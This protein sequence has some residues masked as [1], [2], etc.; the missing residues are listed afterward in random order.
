MAVLRL[1]GDNRP[2][3]T[4]RQNVQRLIAVA[5]VTWGVVSGSA[6]WL[7]YQAGER[8]SA[9][10]L[11]TG[12]LMLV[13]LVAM[14]YACRAELQPSGLAR[15]AHVVQ[16]ASAFGIALLVP[17]TFLPIY[18]IIWIATAVRLYSVNT[19]LWLMAGIT[20]SWYLVMRFL[21]DENGAFL[22]TAMFA[23][24]HLFAILSARSVA[25]AENA[26]DQMATLNREL[27]ATQHLLSEAARQ[28]ER[29]RIARDLHD[30]LGHQLTALAINLQIAER[31]A[32]GDAKPRIAESRAL[33]RLLLSDVREAVS[34]LRE[35]AVL[36]FRR[37]IALVTDKAPGIE[38]QLDIE[39]TL[40]INDVEIAESLLRCV[41]EALTN[42]LRHAGA[43]R[44][45]IRLWQA[46]GRIR[47]HVRDDGEAPRDVHE[48]N[49]L[50][51]MRERLARLKGSL[52]LDTAG[53]A[54]S[55]H[56]EI[57]LPA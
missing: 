36:D 15:A 34:T 10:W 23:T 32:S 13:N 39:E 11:P 1:P 4:R 57:P 44:C 35:Q 37:A 22:S 24:F 19:C 56:I 2:V 46:D 41:Q 12:L 48:G 40:V 20:L 17:L 8:Y 55:L 9:H 21:W 50:N 16:L 30:L 47:L 7:L 25:E 3:D 28:S 33:A 27:V 26:R 5:I 18:T 52:S 14:L 49:G 53:K 6:A 45:W 42:T 43:E 38:V 31:Q 54:L 29:T 51:G